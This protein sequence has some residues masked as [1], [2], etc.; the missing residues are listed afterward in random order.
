[1]SNSI[2]PSTARS[3]IAREGRFE[4]A[5]RGLWA[6]VWPVASI[7]PKPFSSVRIL[8]LRL[9]G[10]KIGRGCLV[11]SKVKVLKP[12]KLTMGQKVAIDESVNIYNFVDVSI[13]D[14]S[15]IS[16]EVFLCTGTHDFRRSDLP[17]V[18]HPIEIGAAVWLCAKACVLPGVAIAD[19]VVVGLASVVTRRIDR[20]W[21]VWAGS[22]SKCVGDRL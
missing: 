1:M 3:A 10:A 18:C 14:R 4:I 13:G 9:F 21:S 5:A 20:P 2:D 15:V 16:R 11:C 19:G 12:W 6:V 22:P 17:L 7:L 8:L